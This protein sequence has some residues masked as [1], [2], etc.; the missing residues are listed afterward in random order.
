MDEKQKHITAKNAQ[1]ALSSKKQSDFLAKTKDTIFLFVKRR[2][3][4][5]LAI[6]SVVIWNQSSTIDNSYV[7][8]KDKDEYINKISS[9][10][11][12]IT[13]SGVVKQYQK[14]IFD[15]YKEKQNVSKVLSDYL[16]QSTYNLTNG[17]E[18]SIF[19][20]SEELYKTNKNLQEFY[21]NYIVMGNQS[22]KNE[23]YK[24][25][26]LNASNDW[27]QILR[28]FT[29]SI[30][31]NDL[32]HTVDVKKSDI[33]VVSWAT[34]G[35]KF[36]ILIEVPVYVNSRNNSN[37]EDKGI[38]TATVRAEGYYDLMNKTSINSNGMFFTK[39]SLNHPKINHNI[40][41][42]DKKVV[43]D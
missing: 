28:W 27:K 19:V 34:T 41:K 39:L 36:N 12:Y 6:L 2:N 37:I 30:N 9:F 33:N 1:K 7:I 35:N 8:I 20:D 22:Q 43:N 18:K 40:K 17:Y 14:E 4:F 13:D 38:T 31:M 15:V 23:K 3:E 16:I 29:T 10:T 5:L 26:L 11:T 21:D 42:D 25:Q 24:E 32:P